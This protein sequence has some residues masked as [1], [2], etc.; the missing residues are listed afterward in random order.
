MI[1]SFREK[2][3]CKY[4]HWHFK[5]SLHNSI[6]RQYITVY[7]RNCRVTC[8]LNVEKRQWITAVA[9]WDPSNCKHKFEI[10]VKIGVNYYMQTRARHSLWEYLT[11]RHLYFTNNCRLSNTE[12]HYYSSDM[13]QYT[14]I[15]FRGY[16]QPSLSLKLNRR[17]SHKYT[18]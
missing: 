8:C 14:C 4:K 16:F 18:E 1:I 7:N 2:Q 3:E 15:I 9:C 6:W 5:A 11:I 17:F 10:F 12:S 13:F